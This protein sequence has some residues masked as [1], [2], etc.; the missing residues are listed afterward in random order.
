MKFGHFQPHG[1]RIRL[2]L[3]AH[4]VVVQSDVKGEQL[5]VRFGASKVVI[6][7]LGVSSD[8]L[9]EAFNCFSK[10]SIF[11]VDVSV[12]EGFFRNV[13]IDIIFF[14]LLLDNRFE[15]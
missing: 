10:L 7:F 6:S 2:N 9:G 3:D 12:L 13:W 15:S 14:G 5:N 8:R 4:L 1:L 11:E